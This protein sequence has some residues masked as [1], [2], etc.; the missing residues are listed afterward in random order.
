MAIAIAATRQELADA[1][2]VTAGAST[3]WVALHSAD[4]GTT[5]GANELSGGGYARVQ[6]TWSSGSGGTL[7]CSP[8]TFNHPAGTITHASLNTA[9][10]GGTMKDKCALSPTQNP[11][12]PGTLTVTPAFT[13]S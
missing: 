4:P 13:L 5:T 12:G 10:S 7:T 6:I 8:I 3:A 9:S 2:K 1:Y 11:G